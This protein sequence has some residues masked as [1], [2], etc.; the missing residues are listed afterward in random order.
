M[1]AKS[2]APAAAGPRA[3]VRGFTLIEFLAVL[4]C[5]GMILWMAGQLLFPMRTAAERQR[6][7]VEARQTARAAADYLAF[8]L[9]GATDNNPVTTGPRA[10][11]ALMMYNR[12][13]GIDPLSE[14]IPPCPSGAGG[15]CRQLTYN[16]VANGSNLADPGTDV[17]T[18][19]QFD[20]PVIIQALGW[21]G[22][23]LEGSS[24][25][26]WFAMGCPSETPGG[27]AA[28]NTNNK[29]RFE[30]I[31]GQGSVP[32]HPTW[33]KPMMAFD[34]QGGW[35]LYQ[36][37]DYRPALAKNTTSCT[38]PD[39]LC[40]ISGTQHPCF[41]VEASPGSEA[42]NPPGGRRQLTART[43]LATGF[44]FAAFRVC[45]GWLQQKTYVF[46]PTTDNNCI[47]GGDGNTPGWT[48]LLPNI[49]D[50]Q[51]AYI[52]DDGQVFNTARQNLQ[53][54]DGNCQ[55]TPGVPCQGYHGDD[56][57]S[58]DVTSVIALR[59]TVV[60][61]S[62]GEVAGAPASQQRRA[63]EDTGVPLQAPDRFQ[64][65]VVSVN[66]LLRNRLPST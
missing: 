66:A 59:V 12:V 34:V 5:L 50:L 58:R 52:Y 16:N 9:R 31:T 8:T 62:S 1:L 14:T 2:D 39:V 47:P 35:G 17:I 25:F 49:E 21:A 32:S 3:G 51:L 30:E 55:L 27:T 7:D 36:I 40:E 6:L 26:W 45:N 4:A 43:S 56:T 64:R 13:A 11:L 29:T 38:E 28:D 18:A 19:G 61:R 48:S 10:P 54:S 23:N 24:I 44:R 53:G 15:D 37:T 57:I 65:H 46:D 42:I 41:S 20:E 22:G 60:A 63:V 33:S